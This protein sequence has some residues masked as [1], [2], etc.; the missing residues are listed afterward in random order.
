MK[1]KIIQLTEQEKESLE[2]VH[3]RIANLE[4]QRQKQVDEWN[5]RLSDICTSKGVDV[6]N[7]VEAN[8]FTGVLKFNEES[9]TKDKK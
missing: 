9:K 3:L 4:S 8:P 7:V 1:E 6:Q 2:V 5:K